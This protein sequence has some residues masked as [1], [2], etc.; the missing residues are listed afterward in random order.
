[1]KT[2]R[3]KYEYLFWI[4]TTYRWRNSEVIHDLDSDGWVRLTWEDQKKKLIPLWKK[5]ILLIK[6]NVVK[7]FLSN[8]ICEMVEDPFHLFDA[9]KII[10]KQGKNKMRQCYSEARGR[11]SCSC[12]S[13]QIHTQS[14]Q[15]SAGKLID[16][17]NFP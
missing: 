13:T 1:M 14:M 3:A 15:S 10:P 5:K 2:C 11:G 16:K 9:Y 8:Q 6:S 7:H 12:A 17:D 4:N